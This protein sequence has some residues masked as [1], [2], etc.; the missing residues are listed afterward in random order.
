MIDRELFVNA[1]WKKESR[2]IERG[3]TFPA[4]RTLRVFGR[5]RAGIADRDE[6]ARLWPWLMK[7]NPPYA[8]YE[9]RTK[10]EI[11]VVILRRVS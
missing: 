2:A 10:R 9:K 11:P 7:Q 3:L 4:L 1:A 8:K 5:V 6:R